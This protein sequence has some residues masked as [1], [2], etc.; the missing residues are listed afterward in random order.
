MKTY[1]LD[2][3]AHDLLRYGYNFNYFYNNYGVEVYPIETCK[4]IWNKE[5]EKM[6]EL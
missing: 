2:L 4:S 5:I 1:N 6:Q 3:I